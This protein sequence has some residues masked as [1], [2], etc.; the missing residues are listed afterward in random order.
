VGKEPVKGAGAFP[1]Q[2]VCAAEMVLEPITGLTVIFTGA[3]NEVH[4]PEIT[5]LRYHLVT[6]NATDGL[7]SCV[8]MPAA[9]YPVTP[10]LVVV[11]SQ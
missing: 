10:G 11:V 6:G 4:T 5:L 7:N 8:V 2:I 3:E 9:V 1:E